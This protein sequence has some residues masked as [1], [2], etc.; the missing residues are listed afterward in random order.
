MFN[1]R[2]RAE[3]GLTGVPAAGITLPASEQELTT[4]KTGS[5]SSP[6]VAPAKL[7]KS[8]VFVAGILAVDYSCDHQPRSV[9]ASTLEMHTSNPA[10]IGQSLG[11]VGHNVAR[12]ASLMGSNV[13]FCSAVGDDLSGKAALAALSQEGLDSA[14]V[15]VLPVETARR[16]AQYISVNEQN[17]DLAI[18]MADMSILNVPEIGEEDVIQQVFVNLWE[19]QL[20]ESNPT[21][22]VVDAN[23]PPKYLQ[24]W[25]TAASTIGAHMSLSSL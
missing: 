10:R 7:P 22:I 9:S 17:K 18:A 1:A 5:G 21:H 24:M 19:P 14:A 12:A 11:G 25:L 20:M 16:T 8:N 6:S 23:W 15:K 2:Q 13:R 3:D 4:T